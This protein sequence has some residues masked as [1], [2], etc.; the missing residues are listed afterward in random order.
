MYK[1]TFARALSLLPTVVFVAMTTAAA[2]AQSETILYSFTGLSDGGNPQGGLILDSK[3]NLYGTTESGGSNSAGTVFELSPNSTGGWNEQVLYSFSGFSGNGDGYFPFGGLVFDNKGNLYGTTVGGGSSFQGIVFELSPASNGTWTEKVLYNFGG[4]A[5][6]GSPQ[7]TS[8]ILDAAGNLYGTTPTGGTYG[9]G[10]V[11][12][13]IAQ[14]NGT[15]TH[16]VIHSFSGGNDGYLPFGAGLIFDSSGNLYGSTTGGGLHDYGV[17]FEL[18]PASGGTWTE[19]VL[20]AF[21]GA[22]GVTS[23]VGNLSLDAQGNIYGTAF[24]VFELS[25]GS[26]GAYTEKDL[27]FF[28]GGSDGAFPESGVVFDSK[29]N[30]Y[31]TTNTG[32]AHRGTVYE[33]S[34][35]SNGGWTEKILHRFSA[36]GGDGVYPYVYPLTVDTQGHLYGTTTDGGASNAGVVYQVTP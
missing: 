5:D 6:G 33:L 22:G 32:G 23:P 15:W 27:H 34:P 25:P 4:G 13:L 31:G 17:V 21:S 29:G 36:T 2:Y 26:N 11:Y 18:I 24:D 8:L 19:K 3:G 20:Y 14:S 7:G 16:R 35:G 30:L 12:E 28:S 10:T 9:Y 1:T